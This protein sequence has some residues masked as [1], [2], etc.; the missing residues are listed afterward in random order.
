MKNWFYGFACNL[1]ILFKIIEFTGIYNLFSE[2]QKN[3][4]KDTEIEYKVEFSK[5]IV[6]QI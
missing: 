2:D 5:Y 1:S 6:S 3:A 4:K